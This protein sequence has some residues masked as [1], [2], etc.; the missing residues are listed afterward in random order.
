MAEVTFKGQPVTLL[1]N[2]VKVGDQA[3]DFTVL[4]NNLNEV[5]LADSQGLI[6]CKPCKPCGVC[7]R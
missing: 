2:Q 5:T 4:D 6:M 7:C 1:G 3:P